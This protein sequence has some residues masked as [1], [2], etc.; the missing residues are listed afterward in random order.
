[1]K[2]QHLDLADPEQEKKPL[3]REEEGLACNVVSIAPPPRQL[4]P[5]S[6]RR[7]TSVVVGHQ[8]AQPPRAPPAGSRSRSEV[9]L[10]PLASMAGREREDFTANPPH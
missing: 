3:I 8:N 10:L 6:H 1:L 4:D 2:Q 9:P 7:T 5:I